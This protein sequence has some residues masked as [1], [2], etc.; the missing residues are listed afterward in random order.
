LIATPSLELDR[1]RVFEL[2]TGSNPIEIDPNATITPQASMQSR[3]LLTTFRV[4]KD[5]RKHGKGAG[6]PF[7]GFIIRTDSL[8]SRRAFYQMAASRIVLRGSRNNRRGMD[9]PDVLLLLEEVRV[10]ANPNRPHYALLREGSHTSFVKKD[11][12][13]AYNVRSL[14]YGP[15]HADLV[16]DLQELQAQIDSIRAMS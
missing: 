7:E 2:Y 15:N 4:P 11:L 5:H 12:A 1:I 8:A 9:D 3:T 10:T 6:I 13:S 14:E 16:T